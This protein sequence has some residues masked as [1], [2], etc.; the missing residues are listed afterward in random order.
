M[1]RKGGERGD[2]GRLRGEEM[3]EEVL[4]CPVDKLGS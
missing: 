3:P 2:K 4:E 1:C